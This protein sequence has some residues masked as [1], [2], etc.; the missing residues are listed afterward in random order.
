[1]IDAIA[2]FLHVLGV[3]IWIGGMFY[4]LFVLKPALSILGK[5]KL[6]LVPQVM[7]RFFKYVWLAIFLLLV[8]GGY[9]AHLH[10]GS[11]LFNIKLLLYLVMVLVFS[12][13]YFVLYKNLQKSPTDQRPLIINRITLLIKINFVL[14]LVIILLIELYKKGV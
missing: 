6:N 2:N 9:R 10:T 3:L 12:F 4:T 14:G 11:Y 8:T 1:M 13:I 5:E 7:G